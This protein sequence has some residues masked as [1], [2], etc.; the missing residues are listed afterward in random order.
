MK[1]CPSCNLTFAETESFCP[2]DGTP[3]VSAAA[4][5]DPQATMMSPPPP[6]QQQQQAY[7]PNQAPGANQTP[8]AQWPQQQAPPNGQYNQPP[9]QGVPY[10]TPQMQQM[11][12]SKVWH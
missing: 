1:R 5:Y 4:S 10:A 3:L 2:K 9:G 8:P 11:G 6:P 7:Y 12:K